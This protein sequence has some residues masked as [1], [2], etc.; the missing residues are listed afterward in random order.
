V[1]PTQWIGRF[2]NGWATDFFAIMY[3]MYFPLPLFLVTVLALRGRRDDFRELVTAIVI[4]MFLGFLGYTLVP[5]GPP[6]FFLEGQFQPPSL[7]GALGWFELT[8]DAQDSI[9]RTKIAASFPSMHAGLSLLSVVYAVRFGRIIGRPRLLL[10]VF[11]FLSLSLWIAT[12]YL[13]HHWVVDLLAGFAVAGVACVASP[14]LRR[15]WPV[16]A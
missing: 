8:Q 6:R 15:V 9:N 16:P 13:R 3:N 2:A 14:W 10:A 4:A 5:V 1:E 12:V 7:H 11:L